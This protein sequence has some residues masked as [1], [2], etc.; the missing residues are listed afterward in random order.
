MAFHVSKFFQDP[1]ADAKTV[2]KLVGTLAAWFVVLTIVNTAID[3]LLFG[4]RGFWGWLEYDLTGERL[5]DRAVL[6]VGCAGAGWAFA[7]IY[8]QWKSAQTALLESQ[9]K[10]RV[11]F[12]HSPLGVIHFDTS[13]TVTAV[14]HSL[15]QILETPADEL[16]GSTLPSVF[17]GTADNLDLAAILD[18]KEQQLEVRYSS[19][20]GSGYRVLT[21]D[22]APIE[23]GSSHAGGIGIV[24]D[25]TRQS[26]HDDKMKA[27]LREKEILLR[28]IH[29]RVKN[30]LQVMYSLLDLQ[31]LNVKNEESVRVLRDAQGRIWSMALVHETLYQ[32]QSV[33]AINAE[34]YL[35]TLVEDLCQ[36][37]EGVSTGIT[38][39]IQ[40]EPLPFDIDTAM[41]LGLLVNELVSNS[42]KHA[43]PGGRPGTVGVALKSGVDGMFELTV[44]DN[45]VGMPGGVDVERHR[46]FGLR[47]IRAL[48]DQLHGRI[49]LLPSEGT[50][51]M[52]RFKQAPTHSRL[53]GKWIEHA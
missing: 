46:S 48:V 45:G 41:P 27:S 17:K 24:T 2:L 42:L 11:I 15:V 39:D 9:E 26:E 36:S 35:H 4:E 20:D 12:D 40:V 16:I 3:Q 31:C 8:G 33:A 22:V 28:E 51:F 43:F 49:T 53:N 50:H 37:Y 32:S 7:T 14:N 13:G 19:E 10:Y 52:I 5:L 1:K 6:A 23:P 38:V 47:L 30:K 44:K 18:G 25:I 34:Q 29:H 21:M